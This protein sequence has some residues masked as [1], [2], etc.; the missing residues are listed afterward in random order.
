V[1]W[2]C[3]FL[4]LDPS[5]ELIYKNCSARFEYRYEFLHH[6]KNL[7]EFETSN[8]IHVSIFFDPLIHQQLCLRLSQTP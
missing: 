1:G 2:V 7:V 8:S 4:E 6:F 5:T 3:I